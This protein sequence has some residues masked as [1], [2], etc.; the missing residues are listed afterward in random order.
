MPTPLALQSH[1]GLAPP[2]LQPR[3]QHILSHILICDIADFQCV[4]EVKILIIGSLQFGI[5]RSRLDEQPK[6]KDGI[7]LLQ[8]S[9]FLGFKPLGSLGSSLSVGLML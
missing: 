6:S 8:S 7:S 2:V 4:Y 1:P 3:A 9:W 5:C